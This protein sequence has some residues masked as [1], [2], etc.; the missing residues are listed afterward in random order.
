MGNLKDRAE[1]IP[2]EEIIRFQILDPLAHRP[3]FPCLLA[4]DHLRNQGRLLQM[5]Q[6]PKICTHTSTY[7]LK[8]CL[9]THCFPGASNTRNP[10]LWESPECNSPLGKGDDGLIAHTCQFHLSGVMSDL[11][12]VLGAAQRTAPVQL[13]F[14]LTMHVRHVWQGMSVRSNHGGKKPNGKPEI[15]T[16]PWP[17]IYRG[18]FYPD[19]KLRKT[20]NKK[21]SKR[22]PAAPC[23]AKVSA[24]GLTSFPSLSRKNT[25]TILFPTRMITFFEFWLSPQPPLH[26]HAWAIHHLSYDSPAPFYRHI[27]FSAV[28][29]GMRG[30]RISLRSR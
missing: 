10:K 17:A 13:R 23:L 20:K 1:I 4:Q 29:L 27:L 26:C 6:L 15:T 24:L 9:L 21:E 28:V 5:N 8:A 30:S 18:S 2:W 16:V 3:P 19:A 14:E 22:M 7:S 11:Q 25:Q 12:K